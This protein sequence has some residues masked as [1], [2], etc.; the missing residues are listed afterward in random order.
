MY[1]V[2][3][4][5]N[6][7]KSDRSDLVDNLETKGITDLTGDETFTELV[8]KVLDIQNATIQ[9][10]EVTITENGTINVEPEAPYTALS[11]VNITT[12]VTPDYSKQW[13]TTLSSGSTGNPGIY[14]SIKDI[15]VT[16]TPAGTSLAQAFTVCNKLVVSPKIINTSNVTRVDGMFRECTS[17]KTIQLFDTSNVTVFEQFCYG[18]ANLEDFPQ[19]NLSKATSLSSFMNGTTN[20]RV[21]K[22]TN[23]SL[24]NLLGSLAGAISFGGTKTLTYI[25]GNQNMSQYYPASTIQA[26]PNYQAFTAAGW[27]IG[28]S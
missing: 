22:L 13:A 9:S 19:F 1:T 25:F 20:T 28:W 2:D 14:L 27:T 11:N 26:L 7:L 4:Y 17:L 18:C 3:E 24:N 6:Q 23:A 16:F 21:T 12:N 5:I 15:P 10:K 8:P